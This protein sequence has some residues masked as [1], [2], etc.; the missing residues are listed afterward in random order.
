MNTGK[1]ESS[2]T[3]ENTDTESTAS[4]SSESL[5]LRARNPAGVVLRK[6]VVVGK[7]GGRSLLGDL[8]TPTVAAA[9]RPAVVVVHGG[10]WRRGRPESVRGF[11]ELLGQAGFICLLAPY[12]LAMEAPWPAQIED[13][14]CDIRFLRAS[15]D[16]L[17]VDPDRI[18]V[19]GD[20]AGGHLALMAA[21]SSPFEG[22]GGHA[23]YSSAV[24]AVGS[25]YGPTR[26]RFDGT[27]PN[28]VA[29]IGERA[30]ETD[31]DRAGPIAYD[32]GCYPVPVDP[33][34]GRRGGTGGE[35]PGFTRQ[36][37]APRPPGRPASVLWRG[38]RIRSQD[39]RRRRRHGGYS[40]SEIRLWKYRYPD[41]RIVF[42][43]APPARYG[44][45]GGSTE[46]GA[47]DASSL[48]QGRR[49]TRRAAPPGPHPRRQTDKRKTS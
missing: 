40:G 14:K 37:E 4:K 34:R 15:S 18:G 32:L 26:V 13:V 9:L 29:L 36:A 38:S 49:R 25:M 31:Y 35:Q 5:V 3:S 44:S 23:E 39:G 27:R 8:Y 30:K 46:G 6:G 7:A 33:W 19:L 41:H 11:G 21:V 28:H 20:S 10:G 17:A 16:S 42:R 48:K 43:K 47:T 24:A 12:R 2:L 1:R 45:H 22:N